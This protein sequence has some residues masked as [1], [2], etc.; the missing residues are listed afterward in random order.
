MAG[1]AGRP[2]GLPFSFARRDPDRVPAG[3]YFTQIVLNKPVP[4]LVSGAALSWRPAVT[5][6]QIFN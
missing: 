6:P 1:Q 2:N 3:F 4:R 5:V